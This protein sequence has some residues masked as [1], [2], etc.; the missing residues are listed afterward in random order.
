VKVSG[1]RFLYLGLAG[2]LLAAAIAAD[3]DWTAAEPDATPG[4]VEISA[5]NACPIA[6][7][8][9]DGPS[10]HPH[11]PVMTDLGA[12]FAGLHR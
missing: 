11:I 1:N 3:T 12:L 5:S 10:G 6:A 9:F 8:T 7:C 4:P 2:L